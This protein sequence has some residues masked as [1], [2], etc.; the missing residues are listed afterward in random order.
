MTFNKSLLINL[1]EKT[2]SKVEQISDIKIAKLEELTQ[3]LEDKLEVLSQQIE[4][5]AGFEKA[6]INAFSDE[7]DLQQSIYAITPNQTQ[8]QIAKDLALTLNR[9]QK[10][11]CEKAKYYIDKEK[12]SIEKI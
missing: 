7:I 10:R 1:P 4:L 9:I 5:M 8:K 6:L 2:E 3:E 11:W 12:M